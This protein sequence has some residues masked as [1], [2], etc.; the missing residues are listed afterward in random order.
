MRT[1][2]AMFRALRPRQWLKNVLVLA[3]P[4]A[5]GRL[6]DPATWLDVALAFVVFCSV[7]SSIYLLNDILD[8]DEDRMHPRKRSRP[9]ASGALPIPPAIAASIL[10]GVLPPLGLVLLGQLPLAIVVGVY[11]VIHIGYC[12]G[13]K[14]IVVID[15][16]A[17]ASGFV[18]RAIGGAVVVAVT[19]SPWFLLVA[20]FGAL[21]IVAGKRYSEKVSVDQ[22]GGATRLSLERYSTSYLAFAW[23]LG[24]ALA[25]ITYCLWAIELDAATDFPWAMVSIIPFGIALLRYAYL[26]DR[27]DADSPEHVVISDPVLRVMG[28]LWALDFVIVVLAR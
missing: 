25:L 13:V 8:R 5:S 11:L 22:A 18:L 26:V 28:V 24:A 14:N 23:M 1:T 9:I 4:L 15:L 3:A 6:L 2:A 21:F 17:V 27:A 12:L 10:L 16:V 19:P 20:S 7:S